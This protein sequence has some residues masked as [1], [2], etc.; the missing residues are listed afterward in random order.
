MTGRPSPAW[1][2]DATDQLLERGDGSGFCVALH[3]GGSSPRALDRLMG[4]LVPLVGRT[5]AP[6]FARGGSTMIGAGAN[7]FS[8]AVA[9]A[10]ALVAREYARPSRTESGSPGLLFG[11][12][13]GGLV[14]LLAVIAGVR[15][16]ALV[17]YEPIVLSLLDH[18][19]ACD[20]V[21]RAWD[22]AVI[23]DFRRHMASGRT[24][25]GVARFIEAYGAAPWHALPAAIREGLVRRGHDLLIEAETTNAQIVDADALARLAVPVLVID[26]DG[27][28]DPA[29]R[30]ADRLAALLPNSHRASVAGAGH[31]GPV[32]APAKVVAVIEPFL[33]RIRA[34]P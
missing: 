11:H 10:S 32:T 22:R 3:A 12:S 26:G 23:D 20:R 16:D 14:A 25:A 2:A 18:A 29:R 5:L 31:M 1:P 28:P 33:R 6:A 8:G 27:S 24:E 21:A 34:V 13:M 15:I 7:G 30:M 9:L 19:D 17:L 4:A